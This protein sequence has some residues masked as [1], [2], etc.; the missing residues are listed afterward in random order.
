MKKKEEMS[1]QSSYYYGLFHTIIK[2]CKLLNYCYHMLGQVP[3]NSVVRCTIPVQLVALEK[4]MFMVPRG[5]TL[6]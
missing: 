2:F 4:E 6:S 1:Y 3:S 5:C